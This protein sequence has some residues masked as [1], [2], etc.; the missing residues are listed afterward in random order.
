MNGVRKWR[1]NRPPVE[2]GWVRWQ[3]LRDVDNDDVVHGGTTWSVYGRRAEDG[4][5]GLKVVAEGRAEHKG[6]YWL[7]VKARPDNNFDRWVATRD[8]QLLQQYPRFMDEL[9]ILVVYDLKSFAD[10]LD[11]L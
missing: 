11:L 3:R 2:E 8:L 6:N 4:F 1:G 10:S 5:F 7:S 9:S